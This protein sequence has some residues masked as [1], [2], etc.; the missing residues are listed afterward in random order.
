MDRLEGKIRTKALRLDAAGH[1]YHE[2]AEKLGVPVTLVAVAVLES[3]PATVPQT[4]LETS[5]A[6]DRLRK[7]MDFAL[8]ELQAGL[9]LKER[10]IFEPEDDPD[11]G[12]SLPS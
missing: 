2:I 8:N 4:A 9:E 6:A 3:R 12:G 7:E 1:S 10:E 11:D 5:I